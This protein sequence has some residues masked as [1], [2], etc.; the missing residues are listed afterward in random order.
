MV[1]ETKPTRRPNGEGWEW[2]KYRV[3]GTEIWAW[4]R[5]KIGGEA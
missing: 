2:G 4:R 5:R 1:D 3:K